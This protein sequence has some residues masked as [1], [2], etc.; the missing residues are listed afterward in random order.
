MK[1][2]KSGFAP[3]LAIL[4]V[5]GI[6]VL[7]SFSI[8]GAANN[9]IPGDILYPIDTG[10]EFAQLNLTNN[11][12]T[13]VDLRTQFMAERLREAQQILQ[14][15]GPG[16]LGIDVA[17]TNLVENRTQVD[18]LVSQNKELQVRVK[19]L[20]SQ[21]EQDKQDLNNTFQ[22]TK[23]NLEKQLE[24]AK[25]TGNTVE[26]EKTEGQLKSLEIQK[27][28]L[29]DDEDEAEQLEA[30]EQEEPEEPEE[31]EKPEEENEASEDSENEGSEN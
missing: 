21:F 22:S 1:N 27:E 25:K 10:I 29:D 31:S 23:E 26:K 5:A 7:G 11:P 2:N 15:Q 20:E 14:E 19:S 9:A 30:P 24:D 18:L 28:T 4:A 3:V 6:L 16:A 12:Q 8:V 13:Q 17:L